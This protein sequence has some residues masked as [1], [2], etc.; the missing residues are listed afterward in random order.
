MTYDHLPRIN[1]LSVILIMVQNCTYAPNVFISLKF[2]YCGSLSPDSL[3]IIE[4]QLHK[5][6]Y[7]LLNQ[8]SQ[9]F[10]L[11]NWVL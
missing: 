9:Y 6:K 5:G 11:I 3:Q 7:G 1:L 4:L 8:R 2:F 10:M